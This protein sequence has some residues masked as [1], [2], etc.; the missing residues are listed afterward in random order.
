M[1]KFTAE[2]IKEIIKEWAEEKEK[3]KVIIYDEK[4]CF[5][6]VIP[7]RTKR[8][9]SLIPDDS[10]IIEERCRKFTLEYWR[11]Q[12]F[13]AFEIKSLKNQIKLQLVFNYNSI[14]DKTKSICEEILKKAKNHPQ[15]NNTGTSYRIV[16]KYDVDIEQC[17][18]KDEIMRK[19]DELFELMKEFEDVIYSELK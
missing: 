17:G 16:C 2:E 15:K 1:G 8:M 7:F 10:T 6:E 18:T 5:K 12:Y 4:L 9:T 11:H 3:Q 13:Y 19:M 14:S